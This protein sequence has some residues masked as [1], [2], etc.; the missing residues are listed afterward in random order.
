MDNK[1]RDSDHRPT[2]PVFK[3]LRQKLATMVKDDKRTVPDFYGADVPY[4]NFEMPVSAVEMLTFLRKKY[5]DVCSKTQLEDIAKGTYWFTSAQVTALLKMFHNFGMV[6]HF[7]KVPGCENIVVLRNKWLINAVAAL[8]RE[9]ELHGS[10]LQDLLDDDPSDPL[11]LWHRTPTGV[12]WNED[13]VKRGCFS[14]DL[15]GYIW[16]HSTKYSKL[17]ATTEQLEFLKNVLTYFDLAH[18]IA[19]DDGNFYLIPALVPNAPTLTLPSPIEEGTQFHR[20][21]TIVALK[22]QK[23]KQLHGSHVNVFHITL[24]FSKEKYL[25]HSFFDKLTCAVASKIE[26]D[27]ENRKVRESLLFY[28]GEATFSWNEHFIYAKKYPLKI[29]VYPIN[30]GL[31]NY[32][33]SRYCLRVF[34][35]CIERLLKNVAIDKLDSKMQ[36]D[37]LLEI[38]TTSKYD[39][40]LGCDK[41]YHEAGIDKPNSKV[42]KMWQGPVDLKNPNQEWKHQVRQCNQ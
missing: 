23:L 21:P 37:Q 19:R 8:I 41:S 24:D 34:L 29:R 2:D 33:T 22:A 18:R 35:E 12:I 3:E 25:S 38:R 30:C 14:E 16:G 1:S 36:I 20:I 4:L 10:M 31:E 15:L 27:F 5:G 40:T 17:A 13:D 11:H 42:L 32:A 7:P 26:K 39:L 6:L 9:E 28:R